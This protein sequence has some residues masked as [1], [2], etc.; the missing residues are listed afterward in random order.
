MERIVT[1]SPQGLRVQERDDGSGLDCTQPTGGVRPF[2]AMWSW[3]SCMEAPPGNREMEATSV[4]PRS[5]RLEI[6]TCLFRRDSSAWRCRQ[7]RVDA[8]RDLRDGFR[9]R[10]DVPRD[11]DD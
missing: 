5:G 4:T 8:T 10:V 7:V 9:S 11:T 6:R 2:S 1:F 3:R